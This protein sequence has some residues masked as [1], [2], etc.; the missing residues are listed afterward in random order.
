M[1]LGS[2]TAVRGIA[3]LLGDDTTV[4][5]PDLPFAVIGN[6]GFAIPGTGFVVSWL[7]VIAIVVIAASWF[8]LRRTVLGVHIYAVGG[9]A[10]A[11]RLSGIK[12]WAGAAVRLRRVRPVVGPRAASCRRR[13]STRPTACSSARAMSSMPSRPSSWAAPASWEASA[14]S[15]ARLIGALIIAV[16]ANGLILT[17]VSDVWQFIIKGLVIIGA[18]AL[19]RY[20]IEGRCPHLTVAPSRGRGTLFRRPATPALVTIRAGRPGLIGP[21]PTG[22]ASTSQGSLQ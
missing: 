20:R 5:N 17:G 1:T 19:D 22:T 9:N 7:I 13:D 15:S 6:G 16:L 4:F 10:D 18:V 14:P 21:G 11:A 3:R 8:I 12:V 2:L